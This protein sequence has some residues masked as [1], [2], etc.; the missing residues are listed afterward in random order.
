[1]PERIKLKYPTASTLS[2]R[3]ARERK[4]YLA[5]DCYVCACRETSDPLQFDPNA[6]PST[7]WSR[8]M[9]LEEAHKLIAAHPQMLGSLINRCFGVTLLDEKH[10]T[11][12]FSSAVQVGRH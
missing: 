4:D 3:W 12:D 2:I 9:T 10:L 1:M 11:I 7:A 6:P 5:G 8:P